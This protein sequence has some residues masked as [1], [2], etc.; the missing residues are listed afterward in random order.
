M[1]GAQRRSHRIASVMAGLAIVGTLL[2]GYAAGGSSEAAAAPAASTVAGHTPHDSNLQ[3]E[4]ALYT[5][6]RELW[7]DHMQW[8]YATVDAYFHNQKALQPTLDRL[9]QNQKD[10]GA[11][12]VPYYGKAAGDELADLLTTHIKQ[13]VPVLKA[14]QAGDKA[15][16]NKALADW[17]ANAKEIA[18]FLS[19]ANPENWPTSATEPMMKAHIDQTTVYAVDL[20]KGGYAEA[21]KDYDKAFDHMMMLSDTLSQGIIAQFPD[22]FCA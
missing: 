10:I 20:L 13:A 19:A 11:A 1:T 21:I 15:A 4:I 16:L 14:A 9:L 22:E 17:Y 18:D 7:M 2:T 8:T 5:T 3:K 12:A 6:M